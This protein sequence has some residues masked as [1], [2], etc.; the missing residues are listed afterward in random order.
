LGRGGLLEALNSPQG[1]TG[2]IPLT[3]RLGSHLPTFPVVHLN[4]DSWFRNAY[5][6]AFINGTAML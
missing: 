1:P 4:L 6:W 2:P 3:S 5:I